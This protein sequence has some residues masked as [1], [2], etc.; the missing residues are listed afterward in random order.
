MVGAHAL[1]RPEPKQGSDDIHPA[2]GSIGS[3]RSITVDER[4]QIGEQGKGD[5]AWEE[6][7]D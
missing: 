3:A 2:I 1:D 7:P 5:P 4:Q 6:P